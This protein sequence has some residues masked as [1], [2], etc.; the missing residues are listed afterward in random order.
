MIKILGKIPNEITLAISGG[1]DSMA[2]LHFL[3]Q[4]HRK[5]HCVHVNH[6][7]P[8]CAN[9]VEFLVDY[10]KQKNWALTV[11]DINTARPAKHSQ[12]EHWRNERYRLLKPFRDVVTAHQLDDVAETWLFSSLHGTPKIIP[13]RRDNVIRPFLATS[14][15]DFIHYCI[16]RN[17]PWYEDKSNTN[18]KYNRNRIRHEMMPQALIVNPGFKNML[19]KRV[20]EKFT[21]LG[22]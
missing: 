16:V 11:L 3:L 2:V 9:A 10:F 14:K 8:E 17:I 12:E 18:L 19:R 6:G 22:E 4:G 7:T 15:E 5:I 13:Y 21:T 20:V 1:V